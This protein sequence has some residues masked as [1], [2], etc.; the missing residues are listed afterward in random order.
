MSNLENFGKLLTTSLRD[1]ALNRCLDIE[2]GR[3]R[4]P[5][6]KELTS[7]LSEF[8]ENQMRIVK[9]L[10]TECVDTGIHDFLFALDESQDEL[11]V[12]VNGDDIVNESDGIQGEIFNDDGWFEK[13]SEH[14]EDGI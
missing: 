11:T 4:S 7:D 9:R 13:F 8:S 12:L 3:M 10:L 6:Y 14:K 2:S 5:D 1:S